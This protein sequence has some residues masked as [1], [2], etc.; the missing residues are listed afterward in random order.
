MTLEIS[1]DGG[2]TF[3]PLKVYQMG[4]QDSTSSRQLRHHALIGPP[5]TQIRFSTS[6]EL[7]ET[8]LY[9]DNMRIDRVRSTGNDSFDPFGH[10]THV[11]G[12]VA[13]N[14]AGSGEAHPGIAP[15]AAIHSVRVLDGEGRG[16][17]SDVIAGLDWVLANAATNNIRVVNL[18]LGKG[19]EESASTD[20]LVQAAER[21][22]MRASWWSPR[23]A[24]TAATD[25]SPSP[26]RATRAR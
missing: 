13:G 9:I 24:T 22:G 5:D 8:A 11:A 3:T 25:T 2:A 23:R 19:I 21:S 18:S 12:V 26:A 17:T 10:G 15:G 4:T 6:N 7:F 14:G 1:D 16:V 20:P